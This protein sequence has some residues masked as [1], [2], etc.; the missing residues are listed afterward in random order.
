MTTWFLWWRFLGESCTLVLSAKLDWS[1]PQPKLLQAIVISDTAFIC[2]YFIASILTYTAIV[3]GI[4]FPRLFSQEYVRFSNPGV[5]WK[6]GLHILFLLISLLPV[7]TLGIRSLSLYTGPSYRKFADDPCYTPY[8]ADLVED[9]RVML[10]C[11][12]LFIIR[13]LADPFLHIVWEP[14]LRRSSFNR[15]GGA[16]TAGNTGDEMQNCT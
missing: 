4:Y 16:N 9:G 3:M 13:G 5:A 8:F 7:Q 6:L 2:V 1:A 11:T 15:G 14:S 10:I 12:G